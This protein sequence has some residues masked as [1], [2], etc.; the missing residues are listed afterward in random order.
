MPFPQPP[1]VEGKP[2]K[3]IEQPWIWGRK[4]ADPCEVSPWPQLSLPRWRHVVGDAARA[5]RGLPPAFL[6]HDGVAGPLRDGLGLGGVHF[7]GVGF[8]GEPRGN[9]VRRATI[10]RFPFDGGGS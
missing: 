7:L 9:Q 10:W 5:H 4:K 2:P 3:Q 8:R 6:G 1:K